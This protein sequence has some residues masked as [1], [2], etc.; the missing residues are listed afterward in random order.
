[1]T[2]EPLEP[3]NQ[4]WVEVTFNLLYKLTKNDGKSI[5]KSNLDIWPN[6]SIRIVIYYLL[7]AKLH[8][9]FFLFVIESASQD[10]WNMPLLELIDF[11]KYGGID[12]FPL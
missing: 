5:W 1:L 3:S 12:R 10:F 9:P 4:S 11:P 8:S 2:L 7:T 6:I